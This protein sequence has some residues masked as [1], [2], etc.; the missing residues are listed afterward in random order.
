MSNA[1]DMTAIKLTE[2]R[3]ETRELADPQVAEFLQRF[4]QT[5]RGQYGEG[6]RFLGIRVPK[7]RRVARRYRSLPREE[8]VELLRSPWHEE[9]LLAL[10]LL[11][12]QYR[13]GSD[14]DRQAIYT[15][16]L[17]HA[18]YINNWDLVDASAEHILGAHLDPE[19][20]T[21]LEEMARSESVWERRMAIMS[22]FHWI[23]QGVF[24]PTLHL[25]TVLLD[26][27]HDLIHKA[28]G[29]M[30]REV[31]K[32]DMEREEEFLR[33]SYRMMPRTMLRYAIEHFPGRR[34]QQYLRGEV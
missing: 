28:V 34:R 10:R 6:D 25:A 27:S 3:R 31:G 29:W 16:Y 23:K 8:V 4:F 11:V 13:R 17:S 5:G 33:E 21:V 7:L 26:D 24:L 30:L 20:F 18:R 12:E 19:H 15:I 32:R 14:V 1:S 22:S 9:R 2:I